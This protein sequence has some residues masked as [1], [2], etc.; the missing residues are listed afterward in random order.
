MIKCPS[1][2]KAISEYAI[3]CPNC[4]ADLKS[5]EIIV[6]TE[7]AITI[8]KQ[9]RKKKQINFIINMAILLFVGMLTLFYICVFLHGVICKCF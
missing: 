6:K 8:Q 7:K 1:C 9:N 3:A 2:G 5:K 4:G